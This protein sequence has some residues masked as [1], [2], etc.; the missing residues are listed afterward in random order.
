MEAAKGFI[1]GRGLLKEGHSYLISFVLITDE[2]LS[3]VSP[4]GETI[5]MG[6]SVT[7]NLTSAIEM[8]TK[9]EPPCSLGDANNAIISVSRM[10]PEHLKKKK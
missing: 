4:S 3:K 6:G 9:Y 8:L 5:I 2:P 10:N 1:F 7:N